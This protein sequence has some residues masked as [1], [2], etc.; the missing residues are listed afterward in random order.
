MPPTRTAATTTDKQ[1]Q[2]HFRASLCSH[3]TLQPTPFFTHTHLANKEEAP[4]LQPPPPSHILSLITS[5]DVCAGDEKVCELRFMVKGF[6][7]E[8]PQPSLAILLCSD[9]ARLSVA[10]SLRSHA[11]C[12]PSCLPFCCAVSLSAFGTGS[13]PCVRTCRFAPCAGDSRFFVLMFGFPPPP[14]CAYSGRGAIDG[15]GDLL[16]AGCARCASKIASLPHARVLLCW[17]WSLSVRS[18]FRV[19]LMRLQ[20]SLS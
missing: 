20:T 5:R 2:E 10:A 1:Q 14:C 6:V 11:V 19:R 12:S 17:S 15:S 18:L 3:P 13:H 4:C 9:C 16:G 7:A 8:P